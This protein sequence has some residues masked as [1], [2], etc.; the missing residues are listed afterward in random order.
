MLELAGIQPVL[1][2]LM[3]ALSLKISVKPHDYADH[4]T[5]Q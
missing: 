1:D 5:I 4:T 3:S 2:L